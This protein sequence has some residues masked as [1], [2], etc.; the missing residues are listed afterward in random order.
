MSQPLTWQ[1]PWDALA[2][3]LQEPYQSQL[4]R[5]LVPGHPLFKYQCT[6]L[7]KHGGTDDILVALTNGQL[8]VV[9]LTW[10]QSGDAQYPSTTFFDSWVDFVA[11]RME[12]DARDYH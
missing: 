6:V 1:G 12:Q 9:H 8:T 5:E 4:T 3:S 7:G 11:Q 2:E 10:G